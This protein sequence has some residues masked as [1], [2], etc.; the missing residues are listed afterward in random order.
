MA[1]V[2]RI[3][4]AIAAGGVLVSLLAGVGR[5]VLAMARDRELPAVLAAVHPRYRIPYRAELVL[6]VLAVALV[7]LFD[8]AEAIG[9]SSFAVLVYYAITNAAALTLGT[10]PRRVRVLAVAGLAGCLVLAFTLPPI[11]VL[12]AVAALAVGPL[13]RG[14]VRLHR[15]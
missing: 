14:I 6:G 15:R 10:G 2:V 13:G 5:T 11:G 7:L 4:G 8:P 12:V 3:G 1:V 9:F